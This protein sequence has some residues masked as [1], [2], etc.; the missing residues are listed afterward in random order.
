MAQADDVVRIEH[1]DGIAVLTLDNPPANL[2]STNV[3]VALAAA[4]DTAA[5]D[6]DTRAV[7]LAGRGAHFSH[8][9]DLKQLDAP[10]GAPVP[11]DLANRIEML[12]KPV[13]AALTGLTAGAGFEL[14]LAANARVAHP[15]AQVMLGDLVLGLPP[16]AGGTQR[17]PRIVGAKPALDL[18]LS[19]RPVPVAD[20]PALIDRTDATDPV[21]VAI[22]LAQDLADTPRTPTRDRR[23]GFADPAA[24][25]AE[26]NR[27]REDV[28]TSPIPAVRD[29][30]AAVEA[31]LLLPFEAGLALEG[32]VFADALASSQSRAQRHVLRAERR[33]ANMPEARPGAARR[34]ERVGILGGG[35]TACGIARALLAAGLPVIQF[36]RSDEALAKA[37]DRLQGAP[38]GGGVRLDGWRG[39]TALADLAQADLVI[40]AVADLLRTKQQVFAALSEISG[41]HTILATQSGLLPIDEI[42]GATRRPEC[43]LGLHFH[44]PVGAARLVE[45]IPGRDT[46]GDAVASVAALVRGR[47]GRVAVRAGT[48]GGTLPERINAAARDAGL[49]MLDPGVPI[50][51][52]DRVMAQWG[53]PQGIFRQ[54]DMIGCDVVLARGRLLAHGAGFPTAHLDALA[55]LVEAGR[56]GRAAG[57][58]FYRWDDNGHAH[59][60]DA[61]GELLSVASVD[62]HPMSEDEIRLRV[63][64]AMANEGARMLRAG[65]ALRP[66][67]IDVACVLGTQFPR[68][69]GGPMKAADLVGLFEIQRALG[70]FS[71]DWPELYSPDP[72]FAALVKNGD[73]FDALN[74]VGRNRR[75][76]PG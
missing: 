74:K 12:G 3:R 43:V 39:T 51:R 19:A 1:R 41:E 6:P 58:G 76:L 34:I 31:A 29:V 75:P 67:D 47:L 50:T 21:A 24:Y 65:M 69:R 22:S 66:S 32:Q 28:A 17:L 56:T 53:L 10:L 36:E 38:D 8:G 72:G 30:V 49:T 54:I 2:L 4:L 20:L 40:E 42:A 55:R 5:G 70:Q 37:R 26:I 18:I 33:A 64:A 27:R 63:I 23:E 25:Q 71:A 45:V 57:R 44:A 73:T 13:V 59:A 62:R 68:W 35:P 52:I 14:A 46:D 7:V 60:D 48:G 61:L 16:G 11:G 15:A 9:L